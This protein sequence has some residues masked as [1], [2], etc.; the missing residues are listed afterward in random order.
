MLCRSLLQLW[1]EYLREPICMDTIHSG[2]CNYDSSMLPWLQILPFPAS[3]CPSFYGSEEVWFKY[4]KDTR[5][6]LGTHVSNL[7]LRE[8][9]EKMR[10]MVWGWVRKCRRLVLDRE[11]GP[12]R[13]EAGWEGWQEKR[14]HIWGEL[15]RQTCGCSPE[16]RE[17]QEILCSFCVVRKLFRLLAVEGALPLQDHRATEKKIICQTLPVSCRPLSLGESISSSPGAHPCLGK[18]NQGLGRRM[19][20]VFK[21]RKSRETTSM[22]SSLLPQALF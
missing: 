13:S 3:P 15:G 10:E 2:H 11:P 14:S 9:K 21:Q 16:S 5:L 18:Q 1:A 4:R 22:L 12:Q 20:R 6:L 7:G 17:I 8:R 19:L